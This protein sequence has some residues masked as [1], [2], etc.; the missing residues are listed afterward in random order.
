MLQWALDYWQGWLGLIATAAAGISL[1]SWVPGVGIALTIGSSLL[2]M[3][4]PFI[5][6]VL[7]AIIWIWS[8]VL[9]PGLRGIFSSVSII[10]T[11]ITMFGSYYLFDKAND[12]IRYRNLQRQANSCVSAVR[13]KTAIEP[14]EEEPLIKLLPWNW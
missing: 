7:S 4:A 5:S 12:T 1:L 8:N 9:F 14:T 11:I 10:L 3:A 2:Q 6:G 13:N